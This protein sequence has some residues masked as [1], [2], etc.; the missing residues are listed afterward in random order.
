MAGSPLNRL[1]WLR[2]SP[3]FI[4]TLLVSPT[5][6]WT[7]FQAGNPL[8]AVRTMKDTNLAYLSTADV[9]PLLG[10]APY[11]GQGETDGESAARGAS[12]LESARFRG[13]PLVFLGLEETAPND[14]TPAN[15]ADPEAAALAVQGKPYFSIDVTD[16]DQSTVRALIQ[17]GS[18]ANPNAE[19]AFAEPRGVTQG[20]SAFD[21]AVF[22]MARSVVDWNERNKFCSACGAPQYSLWA[23]WKLACSSLLPWAENVGRQPCPTAKGLHNIAHPRTDPVVIIAVVNEANDR[24]LLGRTKRFPLGFYSTLVGFI[25]P[26]ESFENCVKREI[27]EEAGVHVSNVRYH[28]TQPW[29]Y[30][31]NL[32]AGFY[33]TADPAEPIRTDLD[34]ELEDAKWYTREEVLKVLAHPDG[35]NMMRRDVKRATDAFDERP[36]EV[37][38]SNTAQAE[39]QAQESAVRAKDAEADEEPAFRVTPRSAVGGV[40]ISDWAHGK[41]PAQV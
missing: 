32:M 3:G 18:K 11:V 22:A 39:S 23:G 9:K 25:E 36:S 38:S 30:P 19:V 15:S 40:L 2:T 41:A 4:N 37:K 28:S 6:R 27:L 1:S 14:F 29:P 7:P 24:I 13:S 16:A 34:N 8:S 20:F 21:A 17:A 26:G 35:T 12:V 10:S 31:A 33:A 5:A